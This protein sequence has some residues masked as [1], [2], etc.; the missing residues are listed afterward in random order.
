[1]QALTLRQRS[2]VGLTLFAMFF[3]AGNVIFPPYLG[4]ESGFSAL[5]RRAGRNR[6]ALGL[7][8]LSHYRCR[9]PD[10]RCDGRSGIRGL[11]EPRRPSASGLCLHLHVPHL[12]LDRPL[13]GDSAYGEHVVRDGGAA[14][15]R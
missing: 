2:L 7:H 14:A 10:S 9:L 13:P 1:M 3:G 5:A 8:R 4:L 11:K 6:V 15:S 12:S